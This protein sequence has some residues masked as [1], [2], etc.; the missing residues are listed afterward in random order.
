MVQLIDW[1]AELSTGCWLVQ[2]YSEFDSEQFVHPVLLCIAVA[3]PAD[4]QPVA[5]AAA[6]A[7]YLQHS[8]IRV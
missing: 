8:K 6:F 1:A 7:G 5:V 2:F 3:Q 4:V